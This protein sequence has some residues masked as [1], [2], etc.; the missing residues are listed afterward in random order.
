MYSAAKLY[1]PY[2]SLYHPAIVEFDK[3]NN[4]QCHN[5]MVEEYGR[6]E[7]QS[8]IRD[9]IQRS[10]DPIESTNVCKAVNFTAQE[11]IRMPIAF[12]KSTVSF[13]CDRTSS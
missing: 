6:D 7:P 5:A 11:L 4:D 8:L 2:S 13:S 1:S 10:I 12:L 3:P 9:L